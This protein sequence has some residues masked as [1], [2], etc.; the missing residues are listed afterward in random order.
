VFEN[1]HKFRLLNVRVDN[2]T[3][4]AFLAHFRTHVYQMSVQ[5]VERQLISYEQGKEVQQALSAATGGAPVWL[6]HTSA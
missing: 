6:T 5:D 4:E 1:T 3:H 2:Q